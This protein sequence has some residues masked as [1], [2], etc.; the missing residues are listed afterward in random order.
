KESIG[1]YKYVPGKDKDGISRY[2]DFLNSVRSF[3]NSI[4]SVC[5]SSIDENTSKSLFYEKNR[6]HSRITTHPLLWLYKVSEDWT[7]TEKKLLRK[8]LYCEDSFPIEQIALIPFLAEGIAWRLLCLGKMQ[9]FC[10]K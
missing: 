8:H 5:G 7:E 9:K 4:N 3:W 10:S 6:L 2:L 1:Y